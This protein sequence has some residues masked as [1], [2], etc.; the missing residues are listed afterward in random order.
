MVGLM[1][2]GKE[3]SFSCCDSGC[4]CGETVGGLGGFFDFGWC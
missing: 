2:K 3:L 1:E 4:G